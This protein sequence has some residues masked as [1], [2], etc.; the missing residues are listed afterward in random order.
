[1]SNGLA[2]P[3]NMMQ[4]LLR[5]HKLAVSYLNQDPPQAIDWKRC[6]RDLLMTDPP[7]KASVDAMVA[8]VSARSGGSNPWTLKDMSEFHSMFVN[9]SVRTS[10]PNSVYFALAE[11]DFHYL[12]I[13]VWKAAYVCPL[14]SVKH[15]VC[16]LYA[17]ADIDAC[18]NKPK[19]V[20]D[21]VETLLVE[22]HTEID[23]LGVHDL[24]KTAWHSFQCNVANA[25]MG[26]AASVGGGLSGDDN[27]SRALHDAWVAF[28]KALAEHLKPEHIA[29]FKGKLPKVKTAAP[30]TEQPKVDST[31]LGINTLDKKDR[32]VDTRARL[33]AKGER[34]RPRCSRPTEGCIRRVGLGH[35]R[36]CQFQPS[37]RDGFDS[38]GALG[39]SG[40][41][42][43]STRAGEHR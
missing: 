5:L 26:K 11:F 9:P 41:A 4:G 13:A 20:L 3:E 27:L 18:R 40:W 24:I 14:E 43:A 30:K 15:G 35:F 8:F 36:H 34:S 21:M 37:G 7:F 22:Y 10:L 1:M 29:W 19:Q 16:S 33:R 25:C 32:A 39:R 31:A 38:E 12:A 17:K 6:K 2:R 28:E 42:G 23:R